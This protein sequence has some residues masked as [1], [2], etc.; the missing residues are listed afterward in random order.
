MRQRNA[1]LQPTGTRA[2]LLCGAT[3]QATPQ[4]QHERGKGGQ[5]EVQDPGRTWIH[6]PCIDNAHN[7]TTEGPA[8]ADDRHRHGQKGTKLSSSSESFHHRPGRHPPCTRGTRRSGD[9]GRCSCSCPPKLDIIRA[10]AG[11]PVRH[12]T[13]AGEPAASGSRE[14]PI[15]PKRVMVRQ[16]APAALSPA[17]PSGPQLA[18]SRPRPQRVPSA[19]RRHHRRPARP[20][21]HA[22]HSA[23]QCMHPCCRHAPER[24]CHSHGSVPSPHAAPD[25]HGV[26]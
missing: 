18:P 17:A 16:R 19:S 24:V 5:G 20:H 26:Y 2:T 11:R 21:A 23:V 9:A 6:L 1:R 3:C 25:Q 8:H 12:A 10:G 22:S 13:A 14:L 7:N 15:R 4:P